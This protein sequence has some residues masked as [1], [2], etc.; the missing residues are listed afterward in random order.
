M[1]DLLI[2]NLVH[3]IMFGIVIDWNGNSSQSFFSLLV[4]QLRGGVMRLICLYVY[5]V[6]VKAGRR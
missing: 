1:E 6:E 4:Y 5:A 2:T 3:T